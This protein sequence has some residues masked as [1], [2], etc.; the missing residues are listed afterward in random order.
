M[1]DLTPL[2]DELTNDPLARGYSGMTDAQ[3]AASLNTVDR[4]RRKLTVPGVDARGA[5]DITE[6]ENLTAA[7]QDRWISVTSGAFL[8]V[9]QG[10]D[11]SIALA[12]FGAGTTTRTA[13]AAL[14]NE[15]ISRAVELNFPEILPDWERLIARARA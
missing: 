15:A 12:L 13:L 9:D 3:V 11:R 14:Q 10:V 2:Q 5:T 6:F 7:D 1:A 8:N 4:T